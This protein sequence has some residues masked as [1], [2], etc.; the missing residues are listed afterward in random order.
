MLRGAT[1][2]VAFVAPPFCNDNIM[3]NE[4]EVFVSYF[5]VSKMVTTVETVTILQPYGQYAKA[6]PQRQTY[7]F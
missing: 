5:T 4:K 6:C 7:C 2:A 3:L 1:N